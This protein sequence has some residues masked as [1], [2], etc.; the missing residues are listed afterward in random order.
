MDYRLQ[1]TEKTSL[2]YWLKI[3]YFSVI[4]SFC[5]LS[6]VAIKALLHLPLSD[7]SSKTLSH[8]AKKLSIRTQHL[9][10]KLEAACH[11][12]IYRKY[13]VQPTINLPKLKVIDKESDMR[14]A[15]NYFCA[16]R[17]LSLEKPQ[18]N[19]LNTQCEKAYKKLN[20]PCDGVCLGMNI[21]FA[22]D[23]LVKGKDWL[24]VTKK[25]QHG[26]S[27]KIAA[28]QATY[29]ALKHTS[30]PLQDL[31][32]LSH[33]IKLNQVCSD[34]GEFN[35]KIHSFLQ[36]KLGL[37]QLN[38]ATTQSAHSVLVHKEESQTLIIDP[39]IGLLTC[40]T[41]KV[42]KLLKKMINSYPKDMRSKSN[43][44]IVINQV[45]SISEKE[46][47]KRIAECVNR[48]FLTTRKTAK[49]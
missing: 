26:A 43:R 19:H 9:D 12:Y 6:S 16:L 30:S 44:R 3:P 31:P 32:Q 23:F 1:F 35:D 34:I 29:R 41:H 45:S 25:A 24:T 37:Y 5:S 18:Q 10:S 8:K 13:L 38:F 7:S 28:V 27:S 11:Y 2:V 15:K 40:S 47:K 33:L 21:K 39:N 22:A 4:S 42:E 17:T 36:M 49:I 14:L 46:A 20:S 48:S